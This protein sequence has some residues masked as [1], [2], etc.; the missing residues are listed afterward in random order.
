MTSTP[1]SPFTPLAPAERLDALDVVRG[2]ALVG[3]CI[4][5]VEFFNRPVVE[6]GQG[7]PAGLHGLDALVAVCV[8]YLFTGKFWTIFSLLF[9]M[10]FALM[11]ERASAAGRPFL[12]AYGRRVAVLGAI[13][14]LHHSLLWS[15]DILIS[16]AVGALA[17]LLTLFAPPRVLVT[18]LTVSLAL[19][20]FPQLGFGGWTVAPIAFAGV[21]GLYLRAGKRILFPLL[22]GIPGV[23]MLAAVVVNLVGGRDADLMAL[24][25]TGTLLIV[26][27]FLAWRDDAPPTARLLRAGVAIVMLTYALVALDAGLRFAAP[28]SE[29]TSTLR[30]R[31]QIAR[32]LQEKQVLTS[33]SYRD[34]VAMRVTHLPPRLRDETGFAIILVGVFLIGAWFARS[35]VIAHAAQHRLLLRR[36]AWI[37]IPLGVGLGVAGAFISTGSPPGADG[38]AYELANGLAT[39]GSLPAALGYIAVVLLMLHSRGVLTK[40]GVLA[41]FGRMALTNYLTQSLV[42]AL[43][44]YGH[45]LGWWGIGRAAQVGIALLLCALQ[46]G[47]S[48]W[49]LARCQYGPAEWVWRA[50]TYLAWPPMRRTVKRLPQEP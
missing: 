12:P 30:E 27:G 26:L 50:L 24:G 10:G 49:W 11:L 5:N 45:G 47:L 7:I 9:G 25:G 17:L 34:A 23:L 1:S 21:V 44:F 4:V 31:E 19:A 8:A 36:L 22:V 14:L 15:G 29:A 3:I 46:I 16:Y 18:A 41:P 32:S 35:G 40:I 48:H 6:S 20:Q 43:L 2:F 39:L 33:G 28:A 13:G 38:G 37:G 42:F